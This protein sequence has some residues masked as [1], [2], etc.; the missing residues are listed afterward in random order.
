MTQEQ[1]LEC[2]G[3]AFFG[4]DGDTRRGKRLERFKSEPLGIVLS[5]L[6]TMERETTDAR[7]V[8]LIATTK[9]VLTGKQT[10]ATLEALCHKTLGL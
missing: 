2:L 10:F 1:I 6:S 4:V 5:E 7:S 3:A 8:R 9:Q